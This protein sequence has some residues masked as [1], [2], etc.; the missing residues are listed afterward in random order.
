MQDFLDKRTLEEKAQFE[1]LVNTALGEKAFRQMYGIPDNTPITNYINN[2][3]TFNIPDNTFDEFYSQDDRYF[4][5]ENINPNIKTA[6]PD[7]IYYLEDENYKY[8]DH[9]NF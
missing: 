7:Q 8:R 6:S 2:G 4:K 1:S 5:E 9:F 3:S